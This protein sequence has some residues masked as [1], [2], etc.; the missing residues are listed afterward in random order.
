[1]ALMGIKAEGRIRPNSTL[2]PVYMHIAIV[3]HFPP[4]DCINI[5]DDSLIPPFFFLFLIRVF[6][7][8]LV[9]F[10]DMTSVTKQ[11]SKNCV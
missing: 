7:R 1:M 2:S 3:G 6:S 5:S 11:Y 4:F 10:P 9:S 8:G